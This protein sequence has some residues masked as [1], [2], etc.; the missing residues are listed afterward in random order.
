VDA[1]VAFTDF[2]GNSRNGAAYFIGGHDLTF[3]HWL[4]HAQKKRYHPNGCAQCAANLP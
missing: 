1:P 4:L 3:V 2:M